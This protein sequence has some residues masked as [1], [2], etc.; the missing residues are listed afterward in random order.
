[1][2]TIV[3]TPPDGVSK[4]F[5]AVIGEKEFFGRTPGEALDAL[6]SDVEGGESESVYVL[7]RC[8]PDE[9]F[10]A[11]QLQRLAQL[12]EK[13]HEAEAGN[14]QL[15]TDERTELEQLI[16]EELEA[17]GKRAERMALE[18]GK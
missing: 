3:I 17:S 8:Q 5:R 1:M 10:N 9:F 15:S 11:Q 18:L 13:L 7:Q 2:R 6:T 12:M 14:K 4:K 16:D